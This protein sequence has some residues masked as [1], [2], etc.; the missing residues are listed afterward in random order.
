M[1]DLPNSQNHVARNNLMAIGHMAR[2]IEHRVQAACESFDLL[3]SASLAKPIIRLVTIR[4]E[5][6]KGGALGALLFDGWLFCS[7]LEPDK[8]DPIRH[9]IPEGIYPLK[10]FPGFPGSKFKHT[11]EVIVPGHTA[12]LYHNGNIE[13]HS[14]MCVLLAYEPGYLFASGHN[15]RAILNSR[16]AYR[17]FQRQV[18]PQ[19]KEGDRAAF[20]N[21]YLR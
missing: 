7:T 8:G 9:Q 21:F 12:V 17:A 3:G 19:I 16:K 10:P 14:D 4:L 20:I 15:V 5:Q 18:V 11:L 1:T 6:T 2:Q 13:R